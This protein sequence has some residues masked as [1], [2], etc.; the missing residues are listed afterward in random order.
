MKHSAISSKED[1]LSNMGS[2]PTCQSG[3]PTF[4]S[5]DSE[6]EEHQ[7]AEKST[8]DLADLETHTLYRQPVT[9]TNSLY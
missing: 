3:I 7:Q 2:E 8:L 4:T 1:L 6:A 5:I 9:L